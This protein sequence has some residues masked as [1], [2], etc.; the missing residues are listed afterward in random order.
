MDRL[1]NF[2]T[3]SSRFLKTITSKTKIEMK[4]LT[5][6]MC[7]AALVLYAC[8]SETKS[9]TSTTGDTTAT[10]TDATASNTPP[11]DPCAG[12]PAPDPAAMAGM[13]S[14][15]MAKWMEFATPGAAHKVLADDA[16]EWEGETT[17]W[18][19]PENPPMKS[20]TM[21]VQSMILGGRYQQGVYT[22][23]MMGQPFEGRSLMGYDNAKKKYVSSWADNMGTAIMMMEGTYN[24]D[25]KTVNLSGSCVD[26]MTGKN[27]K[28][29]EE[30]LI[31]DANTRKMTMYG[32]D[33]K[34]KEF[35]MMEI[36]MTRK[37]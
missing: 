6:A 9:D 15:M 25:T 14:A 28:M 21:A 22:G 2:H 30:F 24:T 32:P 34:G 8:N 4:R 18:M 37:K 13:D 1:F 31:V 19:A 7:A 3:L 35:K 20:K 36:V 12:Q 23:C 5:L 27:M 10:K 16:G 17:S 26:P 11:A 29:R 33:M